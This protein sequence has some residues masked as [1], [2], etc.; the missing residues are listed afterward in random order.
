MWKTDR[1]FWSDE[2][3]VSGSLRVVSLQG[4][5][6]SFH[7]LVFVSWRGIAFMI[8]ISISEWLQASW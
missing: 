1:R 2:R 8:D 6:Q 7:S 5:V 4:I 3:R